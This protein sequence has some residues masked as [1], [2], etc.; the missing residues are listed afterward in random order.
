MY[1]E[2]KVQKQWDIDPWG[3]TEFSWLVRNVDS[4][5]VLFQDARGAWR[6]A[7]VRSELLIFYISSW[8]DVLS[9]QDLHT[10]KIRKENFQVRMAC[11]THMLPSPSRE[12]IWLDFGKRNVLKLHK[13]WSLRKWR[14]WNKKI[15]ENRKQMEDSRIWTGSRESGRFTCVTTTDSPQRL[16]TTGFC[17]AH[18]RRLLEDQLKEDSGPQLHLLHAARI[19]A[20]F[21][22]SGRLEVI[23][24]RG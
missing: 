17:A 19:S 1:L 8:N 21:H 16:G 4:S 5:W 12:K 15:V 13:P 7:D 2:L 11:R 6:G 22:T 18:H 10:I 24:K 9:L 20:S 3:F 23:L 14:R